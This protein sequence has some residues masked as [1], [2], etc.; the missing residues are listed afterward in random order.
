MTWQLLGSER[1]EIDENQREFSDFQLEGSYLAASNESRW[2]QT[3][4]SK[5]PASELFN[6]DSLCIM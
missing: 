3:S 2:K 5:K 6:W 4:I 1:W